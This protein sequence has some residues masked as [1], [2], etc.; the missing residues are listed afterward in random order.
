MT[1]IWRRSDDGYQRMRPA[2]FPYEQELHELVSSAPELLPLAGSPDLVTLGDEVALGN[3]YADVLALERSGRFVLIEV[4]LASNSEARR[5]VVAQLLSYASFLHG[6]SVGGLERGPLAAELAQ[7]G[8]PD[9]A[10]L[11]A[12][13][14][15]DIGLGD[16][17]AARMQESLDAGAF[18]LVWVLDE[19]PPE[20][21]S[22]VGYLEYISLDTVTID[23]V[24]V[25]QYEVGGEQIV[26]PQR[27]EPARV[28]ARGEGGGGGSD[29]PV[30]VEGRGAEDFIASIALAPAAGQALLRT[31]AE[32]ALALEG[33]GLA[34][35][36]TTSGVTGRKVM[37]PC[38]P[39]EDVG[40]VTLWSENGKAALSTWRSVFER[41]APG[42]IDAVE[43]AAGAKV[44]NGNN[45][46]EITGELLNALTEAY[47]EAAG[48]NRASSGDH[49]TSPQEAR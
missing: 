12:A 22:L 49:S 44:G 9:I 8:A 20:L 33:D 26:V 17:F 7:R 35:L 14:F 10:S 47:R 45:L 36:W 1:I 31:L 32:W 25:S 43:A 6:M 27:V 37:K 13:R 30:A 18:R 19:A 34:Q 46:P 23:L 4:K 24:T 48:W 29:G 42:S 15:Q 11:A 16:D 28:P 40:L 2:A 3:G 21:V 41:C 39:G 5:A 38:V